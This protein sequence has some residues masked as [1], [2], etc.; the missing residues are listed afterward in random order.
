MSGTTLPL[1]EYLRG[2]GSPESLASELAINAYSH[3]ELPLVGFKYSQT[4]SPKTHPIVRNCRGIVLERGT[5]NV[6]AK[7]FCR[8][9]NAG[10]DQENFRQF[11]WSNFTCTAKEDGS[12]IIVYRYRNEWHANT[13]GSFGLGNCGFSGRSWR[14][15]FWRT[16]RLG[17]TRLDSELTY[18]WEL[19][20][21]HNKVI[22]IY[23]E[24]R[25]YLLAAIETRSCRELSTAEV[26]TI[27]ARLG[28]PTPE[29]YRF[30]GMD[31]IAA[32]L[33]KMEERDKTYEGVV[34]RGRRL[35]DPAKED[36]YK[37]KT[38][39]YLALHRLLD[40]GNLFNPKRLVP[41]VLA[42]E[43]DE[44]LAY[45]PELA[46][47]L[48]VV[49]S[50]VEEAFASLRAIWL[51]THAEP[52]Q[53][54]FALSI[55]GKTPFTSVLFNLRKQKGASQTEADLRAIWRQSHEVILRV[56]YPRDADVPLP[57]IGRI[58][59]PQ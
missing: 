44:V 59:T 35:D 2:G 14:D 21:P 58:T 37:I 32:F 38:E 48:E 43:T 5:W 50:R 26:D 20:T 11:D 52:D 19:C 4:E 40:N 3:P 16:A 27:A 23:P 41:L 46:P 28:V 34:I 54:R 51:A 47:H 39:T 7:P 22:R 13:S 31:D 57:P 8:F 36:R 42:G 45:I 49:S 56:L 18:I 29:R 10:E 33:R 1:Q 24:P 17:F 15:V 25:A 12:L 55:V 9:F 30:S 53:K 6:V